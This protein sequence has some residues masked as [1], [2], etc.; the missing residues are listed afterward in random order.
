MPKNNASGNSFK[1]VMS[2]VKVSDW[3]VLI[4]ALFLLTQINFTALDF[5]D[6][7][8]LGTLIIW[9]VLFVLRLWIVFKHG[10]NK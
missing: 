2:T 4:A 3:L 9:A 10:S 5:L 8:Y 6:K 7:I 1:H